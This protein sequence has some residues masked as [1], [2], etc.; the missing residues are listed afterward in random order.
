MEQLY[1]EL[2]SALNLILFVHEIYKS[3]I[4]HMNIYQMEYAH[5]KCNYYYYYYL[6]AASLSTV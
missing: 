2:N 4:S 1:L 6:V 3:V 5:Y